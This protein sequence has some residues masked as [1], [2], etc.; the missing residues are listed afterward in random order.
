MSNHF[1]YEIDE[2]NLRRQLNDHALPFKEEAWHN[3]ERYTSAQSTFKRENRMK[4]LN[5]TLN[6][7][8][9]LP[10]VFG[11]IVILFSFLLVNFISIK[12]PKST[13]QKAE[14]AVTPALT[15]SVKTEQKVSE[16]ATNPVA[17]DAQKTEPSAVSATPE[18]KTAAIQQ[19]SVPV[20][21]ALATPVNSAIQNPADNG[22]VSNSETKTEPVVKK[23]HRRPASE[24]VESE[25]LPEIRPTLVTE[26][27]DADEIRPN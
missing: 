15:Q 2:R 10:V 8:V 6:R 12:N 7:N 11:V 27:R 20:Q 25:I 1:T 24:V 16:K 17:E 22:T 9:V 21:N 19:A 14:T 18:Q 13:E 3:F 4:S 23:K 5:I 26:E